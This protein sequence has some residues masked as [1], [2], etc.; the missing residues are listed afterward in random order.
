M[1]FENIILHKRKVTRDVAQTVAHLLYKPEALSSNP[2]PTHKKRK[3]TS[4]K[5]CRFFHIKC[6]KQANPQRD[7]RLMVARVLG[8][9][10][11]K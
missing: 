6:L 10:N 2:I 3:E 5:R 1:N 9:K 8:M 4:Y 11:G 7:H